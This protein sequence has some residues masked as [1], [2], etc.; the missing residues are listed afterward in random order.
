MNRDAVQC[1]TGTRPPW[2]PS[3]FAGG[4]SVRHCSSCRSTPESRHTYSCSCVWSV[5]NNATSA[6]FSLQI[7]P[8]I[9]STM[10]PGSRGSVISRTVSDAS[11]AP[12]AIAANAKMSASNTLGRVFARLS[13]TRSWLARKCCF[14]R[15]NRRRSNCSFRSGLQEFAAAPRTADILG[16]AAARALD[17]PEIYDPRTGGRDRFRHRHAAPIVATAADIFEGAL[18]ISGELRK[19]D[20]AHDIAV[21][22]CGL[23]MRPPA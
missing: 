17:A 22:G 10:S 4:R 19:L 1:T 13:R 14:A 6:S 2:A 12:A 23:A 5:M 7:D 9:R 16:G 18:A 20:R 3:T 21:F 8:V 15:R 11:S